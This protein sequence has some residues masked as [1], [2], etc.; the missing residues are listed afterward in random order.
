MAVVWRF[1]WNEPKIGG[2]RPSQFTTL[3]REKREQILADAYELRR[4]YFISHLQV[5]LRLVYMFSVRTARP[6]TVAF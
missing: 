4:F 3:I 1:F 6:F 5:I 2:S